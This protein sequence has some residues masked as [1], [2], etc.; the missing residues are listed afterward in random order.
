V[1]DDKAKV[2]SGVLLAVLQVVVDLQLVSLYRDRSGIATEKRNPKQLTACEKLANLG[3]VLGVG[4]GASLI[5]LSS[6][7]KWE[8]RACKITVSRGYGEDGFSPTK[9]DVVRG[10]TVVV[11]IASGE[12]LAP[13]DVI[14]LV[15]GIGIEERNE[16]LLTGFNWGRHG[17]GSG[18]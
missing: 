12:V 16:D 11:S 2:A 18:E 14:E 7:E 1:V 15:W 9:G 8:L 5:E 17:A 10:D 4:L 6:N 3:D 13:G